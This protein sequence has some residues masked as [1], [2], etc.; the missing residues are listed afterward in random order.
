[1]SGYLKIPVVSGGGGGVD[2]IFGRTG[3]VTAQSGDYDADQVTVT[4]SGNLISTN[5]QSALEELNGEVDSLIDTGITNI[6]GIGSIPFHDGTI[7]TEDN[8]NLRFDN[9]N[10][11]LTVKNNIQIGSVDAFS[12]SQIWNALTNA[13]LRLGSLGQDG[14]PTDVNSEGIVSYGANSQG[15]SINSGD[16][17]FGY[18]RIK[19]DRFG[20]YSSIN[21]VAD[22][23]WR[24]DPT[25]LFLRNDSGV[26]TFEVTR[27]TG[28]IAT[29][30]TA[31]RV[32]ITDASKNLTASSITSTELN[33][34]SGLNS[35]IQDQ[36]DNLSIAYS[37]SFNSTTDWTLDGDFYLIN[38]P[39]LTHNKGASPNCKVY[40]DISS[41]FYLSYP[42]I[43]MNSSG[44]LYIKVTASPDNRFSGKLT[45]Q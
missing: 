18:A 30:I 5:V 7:F 38:I 24:V 6:S 26:K 31:S 35:N 28:N 8:T 3:D 41:I 33:Y 4:P 21:N 9:D 42:S 1:M 19:A 29:Q 16:G 13:T 10:N 43:S 44:D 20:L 25:S 11:Y 37:Q 12:R 22:Y 45:V 2:S 17:N 40:E 36:I 34:L 23:Y 15:T 27:S 32:L 39:V 14:D